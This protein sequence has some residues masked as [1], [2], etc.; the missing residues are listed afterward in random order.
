MIELDAA[1]F[2]ATLALVAAAACALFV[3]AVTGCRGV[4]SGV[5]ARG[6][7]G[8]WKGASCEWS[9]SRLRSSIANPLVV[10]TMLNSS[11]SDSPAPRLEPWLNCCSI[12]L[13]CAA[14]SAAAAAAA[15]TWKGRASRL[16]L[17]VAGPRKSG[18]ITRACFFLR[19]AE[20]GVLVAPADDDEAAAI[21]GT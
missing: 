2:E 10:A 7:C 14:W 8:E 19:L 12:S 5:Y 11:S 3:K 1:A 20:R 13:C 17:G 18:T 15:A 16:L 6:R 21:A 9:A 4:L